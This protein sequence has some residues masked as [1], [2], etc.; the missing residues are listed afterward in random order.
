M[1]ISLRSQHEFIIRETLEISPSKNLRPENRSMMCDR[2]SA[3][4]HRSDLWKGRTT[5]HSFIGQAIIKTELS[6]FT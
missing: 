1:S 6:D 5:E 3:S 4:V 2:F